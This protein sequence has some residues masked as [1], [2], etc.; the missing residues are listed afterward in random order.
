MKRIIKVITW[1]LNFAFEKYFGCVVI[2]THLT[3]LI[4]IALKLLSRTLFSKQS[5]EKVKLVSTTGPVPLNK[6]KYKYT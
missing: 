6:R 5:Y 3:S 2:T 1:Q 4:N